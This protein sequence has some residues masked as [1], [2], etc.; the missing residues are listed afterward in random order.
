M[1]QGRRQS[2]DDSMPAVRQVLRISTT[3]GD[4]LGP[5]PVRHPPC[6]TWSQDN[7]RLPGCGPYW[8]AVPSVATTVNGPRS[9]AEAA[10]R[11]WRSSSCL[12]KHR[13][14]V[15]TWPLGRWT[16]QRL[17]AETSHYK[18]YDGPRRVSLRCSAAALK[19]LQH[20]GLLRKPPAGGAARPWTATGPEMTLQG[21]LPGENS[22]QPGSC[23]TS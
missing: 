10:T 14:H 3:R 20:P 17:S 4:A 22:R 5:V 18:K 13:H 2:G 21:S 23:T 6:H 15:W 9:G 1:R 8:I 11:G 16:P 12:L 7:L 19:R